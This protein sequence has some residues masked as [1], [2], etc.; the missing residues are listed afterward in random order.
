MRKAQAVGFRLQVSSE[1]NANP[2]DA[3]DH[4]GGVWDLP[5][6]SLGGRRI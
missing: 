1:I 5:P 2:A 3:A 6:R 4:P